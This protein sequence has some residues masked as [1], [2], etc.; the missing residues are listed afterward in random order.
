MA[1]RSTTGT[2]RRIRVICDAAVKRRGNSYCAIVFDVANAQT[3][4]SLRVD[5]P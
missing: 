3:T 4:Y 2:L 5:Y 1:A